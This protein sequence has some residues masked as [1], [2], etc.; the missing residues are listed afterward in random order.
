M[1]PKKFVDKDIILSEREWD[2][3]IGRWSTTKCKVVLRRSENLKQEPAVATRTR[4]SIAPL[5]VLSETFNLP[6]G[7]ELTVFPGLLSKKE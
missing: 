4:N 2:A 3:R 6:H 1:S 7:G 5:T